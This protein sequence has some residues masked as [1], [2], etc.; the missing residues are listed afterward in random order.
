M[1][2]IRNPQERL[3]SKCLSALLRKQEFN[4]MEHNLRQT[5]SVSFCLAHKRSTTR[6]LEEGGFWMI[7]CLEGVPHS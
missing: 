5:E 4:G 6:I 3:K 7:G 2:R 1:N